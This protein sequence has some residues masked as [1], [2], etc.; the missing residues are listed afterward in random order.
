MAQCPVC[1]GE[2]ASEKRVSGKARLCIECPLC[3]EYVVSQT[4]HRSMQAD[5]SQFG[6]L[7]DYLPAHTRQAFAVGGPATSLTTKNWQEFAG[8]HRHTSVRQKIELFMRL[9]ESRTPAPG[10]PASFDKRLDYPL[11]D[12][13]Y[14]NEALFVLRHLVNAGYVD[15][16]INKA[17]F[18]I[19]VK[20]WEFLTPGASGVPGICFVAMSAH[21]ELNDAYDN[22]ILRAVEED[23]RFKAIRVDRSEHNDSINDKIMAGIQQAQFMV[24][25]FTLQR[26]KEV[27]PILWTG[28]RHS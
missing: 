19:T 13:G 11:I 28:F 20:G 9:L 17:H 25:D 26:Q 10:S 18:T 8:A 24:A 1:N 4:L 27:D 23:C 16:D 21:S 14:E 2:G 12:A 5:R 22:G 3:G 15:G 7:L 6:P